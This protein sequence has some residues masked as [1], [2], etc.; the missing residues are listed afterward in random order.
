[1]NFDLSKLRQRDIAL[2]VLALVVIAAAVWYFYMYRPTLDRVSLLENDVM[3]LQ[4]EVTRGE[5]AE[6]NLDALRE[7]VA[8]LEQERLEFLSELPLESDV[9]GLLEQV[10]TSAEA[11]GLVLNQLSQGSI[12]ESIADV[13]PV[14]FDFVTSGNY[15]ETM[16]FLRAL[17]D[18]QRYAKIRQV[19]LSA[20]SE[21]GVEDPVLDSNFALTFYVYTGPDPGE[22]GQ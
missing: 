22:V 17:E 7:E 15:L 14:A 6:R 11:A 16:D 12:T 20:G 8:I 2:I 1:M 9:S 21:P 10:R 4:L 13:R 5:A 18:L 19:G 3:R